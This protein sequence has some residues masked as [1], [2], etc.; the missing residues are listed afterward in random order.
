M[1]IAGFGIFV[2]GLTVASW[3]AAYVPEG[4]G[5]ERIS[6]WASRVGLE[7]GLGFAAML[8]GVALARFSKRR[9]EDPAQEAEGAASGD[10]ASA[11]KQ[12]ETIAAQIDELVAE[13]LTAEKVA[14]DADELA[15]RIDYILSEDVPVFLDARPKIIERYGL[16][17]FAELIGHFAVME[18]ATARAWSAITDQAYDE[19]PPSLEKAQ[20]AI[21]RA[22]E[23]AQ[24]SAAKSG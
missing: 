21:H 1:R 4:T 9:G 14:V 8:V 3:Y 23:V 17:A 10:A 6:N 18:R 11:L 19:V 7:F 15:G 5:A 20:A 24:K 12:I 13:E 2:I 16:A 22:L